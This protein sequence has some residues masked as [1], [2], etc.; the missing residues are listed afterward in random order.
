MLSHRAD[1]RLPMFRRYMLLLSSESFQ[2]KAFIGVATSTTQNFIHQR[3]VIIILTIGTTQLSAVTKGA[4][5]LQ[6]PGRC[7]SAVIL[8][9]LKLRCNKQSPTK[10]D[11][12]PLLVEQVASLLNTFMPKREDKFWSWIS[13]KPEAKNDC[14][15][16]THHHFNR[17]IELWDLY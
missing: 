12:N 17:L 1:R 5:S 4:Q 16:E 8:V 13:T 3:R 2:K 14:A 9:L 11:Q 7:D 6:R 15:G 10:K